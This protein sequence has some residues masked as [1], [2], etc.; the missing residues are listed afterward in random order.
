MNTNQCYYDILN[1]SKT[2]T[3]RE[4]KSAYKK[5]ALKYHPDKCLGDQE[6]KSKSEQK[7]KDVSEAYTVLSDENS[8]KTYDT[9]GRDGLRNGGG[10]NMPEGVEELFRNMG[11][12]GGFGGF[13]N[14]NNAQK[15][16]V[17]TMPNLVHNLTVNMK[18]I[19]MGV[20]IV[21]KI[22]RF[23]LKKNK[24]IQR[25][26][27]VC[28]ICKGDGMVTRIMQMGPGMMTQTQQ[29][30]NKC[31]GSGVVLSDDF[32]DKIECEVSRTIPKGIFNGEK[33]VI[34]NKG[35]DI[36]ECFRDKNTTKTKTDLIIVIKETEFNVMDKKN[37]CVKYSRGVNKNPFDIAVELTLDAHEA[38]C[39]TYTTLPFIDGSDLCVNIPS[40]IIFNKDNRI[41]VIPQKG[42][43]YYK[44]KNIFGDL[45]IIVNIKDNVS[46]S[47]EQINNIWNIFTGTNKNTFDSAKPQNT[48]NGI[49]IDTFNKDSKEGRQS[50]MNYKNYVNNNNNN[51]SDTEEQDQN[52]GC[53]QQ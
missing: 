43:P 27:I 32:F 14:R 8:R 45:Y 25:E 26:N 41:I 10:P 42:M 22:I 24:Q 35:H 12:F 30:C 9:Y 28:Q 33:I 40:G 47:T 6:E 46:L 4:I 36:P 17:L 19:Y 2:A 16:K 39:G 38:I 44:Q 34:E 49:N 31:S 13:N 23:V 15:K 52:A 53:R 48:V 50:K 20:S 29:P 3:Q 18:D 51:D 11:G 21:F 1:V 37:T 7:F 5:C